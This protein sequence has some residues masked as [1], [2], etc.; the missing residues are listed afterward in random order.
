MITLDSAT[1][2]PE[3]MPANTPVR[4]IDRPKINKEINRT[5]IDRMTT[6]KGV[7]ISKRRLQNSP[8]SEH[9]QCRRIL[10]LNKRSHQLKPHPTTYQAKK[11]DRGTP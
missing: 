11:F 3:V 10:L 2:K 4:P 6:K 8:S 5:N 7:I 9:C 1:L